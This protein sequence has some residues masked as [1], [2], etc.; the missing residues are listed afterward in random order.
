MALNGKPS[1]PEVFVIFP[2]PDGLSSGGSQQRRDGAAFPLRPLSV[3][4]VAAL[5]RR[6][7]W[8]ATVVDAAREP[9]PA[10]RPD[11]VMISV[12][13]S[14]A[15]SAYEL[16]GRYRA[17]GVPVVVGGVH[18]SI[19]PTE[20]LRWADSVV[21]GEAESVM[22]DVLADAAAG[23][24][25]RIYHG[26]FAEMDEVPGVDE[27]LDLYTA[28]VYRRMPVHSIQT[29]RGCRFNCSYCS[30]IRMNGRGM[31]HMTPE[32]VV[33][34]VRILRR[35]RPRLPG[36][37]PVYILDD[38]IM[39]DRD[40][41]A[42]MFE[43]L[44]RAGVRAPLVIQASTGFGRDE[45]VMSLAARAGCVSV[46]M[47]FESL[48]R[49]NLVQAN[50]KNRPREY[51]ELVRRV[52]AHGIGVS[53]GIIF[54]FD[55]DTPTVFDSTVDA[56]EEIGVDSARFGALT[57]L[58]GTQVFADMYRE[59]RIVDFDW[60]RYD[61]MHTVIRP[62]LMSPEQLQSGLARAYRRWYAPSRRAARFVR[63]AR[64]VS[65]RVAGAFALSGRRYANDLDEV[66]NRRPAPFRPVESDLEAL[67][68]TSCAP[69]SEA[70][71]V[72][73]AGVGTEAREA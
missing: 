13:T 46:F 29:S 60:G 31:R 53:A 35:L 3:L 24:L 4:V 19:L 15:P 55:H 27:Y 17:E 23:R 12:W 43:A 63:Q 48:E 64:G 5:A 59:G 32:R 41:G 69:A 14:L 22:A 36:G 56:L 8:T 33:E 65:L 1:R 18:A 62:S 45:E 54:G 49:D 16:A 6:A 42:E 7:G 51:A 71:A 44:V 52:H 68:T 10:R 40:Y 58:P 2:A 11:L 70:V 21:A 26:G 37:T 34:Q 61:A 50:K 73:V 57:P 28:P 72:A 30:V 39:S 9:L 20:A 47:G 66:M 25:R 38:D 67:V